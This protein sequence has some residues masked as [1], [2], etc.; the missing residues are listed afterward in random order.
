M[1]SSD[2]GR[3]K[4]LHQFK[5]VEMIQSN[6]TGKLPESQDLKEDGTVP[7]ITNFVGFL[8]F[9]VKQRTIAFGLLGS[10]TEE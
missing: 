6:S 4:C 8:F 5:K 9:S 10:P 2:S 1:L 7:Q 3:S